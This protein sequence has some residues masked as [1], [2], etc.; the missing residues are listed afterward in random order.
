MQYLVYGVIG[1]E[2]PQL[3]LDSVKDESSSELHSKHFDQ[4]NQNVDINIRQ[5]LEQRHFA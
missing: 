5:D 4:L 3:F 2:I 1:A